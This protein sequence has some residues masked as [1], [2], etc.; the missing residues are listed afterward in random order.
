MIA[1]PPGAGKS[2]LA[3]ALAV[4]AGSPTV[5][6]SA[7]THAHTMSLRLLA[8]LANADQAEVEPAMVTHPEWVEQ[9]LRQAD[10]IRWCFDSAPSVRSIEEEIAAHEELY[11]DTPDLVVIDNLTDVVG[12]EGDEWSGMRSL[13]KD[14]KWLAREHDTAVLVLHHTSEA[15]QLGSGMCPPM[16]AL[17]GKVAQ[18]PALVLTVANEQAGVMYV[19][20][21]KNRYGPCAPD[22][23]NPVWLGYNPAHMQ[24]YDPSERA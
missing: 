12:G 10:H 5:Y 17:Q 8:M 21:V 1:G 16:R 7:D 15:F 2:T 23:G 14:F 6:V 18:T 4:R 3:L 19:C 9:T 24:V 13:M 22:G 20:P 11:G